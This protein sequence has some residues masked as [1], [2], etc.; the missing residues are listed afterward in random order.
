MFDGDSFLD[1]G[2]F[3]LYESIVDVVV[4]VQF[5]QGFEVFFGVVVIDELMGGFGEEKDQ[6]VED[7]CWDVLDVEIDML[8]MVIIF[9]K[10]D[11]CV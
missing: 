3:G 9:C 11:E 4:S 10:I 8:L 2:V 1:L 7:V 5:G 6:K